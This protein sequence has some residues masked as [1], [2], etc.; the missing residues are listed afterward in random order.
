MRPRAYS[1]PGCFRVGATV[2]LSDDEL[3]AA[4]DAT[5]AAWRAANPGVSDDAMPA[6]LRADAN[7]QHTGLLVA[8]WLNAETARQLALPGGEPA[9]ALHVTL[10]YCGDTTEMDDLTL[11]RAVAAVDR[12]VSYSAPLTGKVAGY[13]RF[14]ASETSDGRDVFY[15]AVDVPALAELRQGIANELTWAGCPPRATHGFTPHITLAYLDPGAPN[16]V[17]AVPSWP[18]R[19]GAVTVRM[20]D[21]GLT[22]PLNGIAGPLGMV[23]ACDHESGAWALFNELQAYADAPEWAPFLPQPGQYSHPLYGQINLTPERIDRFVDQFKAGVYQEKLPVDAEH[24]L[25]MSGAVG[26]I[27]DMRVNADGSADARVDWNDRGK[28]LIEGDRFRYVSPSWRETWQDPVTDEVYRDVAIGLAITTRPFFK[29]RSGLRPLVASEGQLS[30]PD[31]RDGG[32]TVTWRRDAAEARKDTDVTK[33]EQ[34]KNVAPVA[35]TEE[36]ARRFA[37]LETKLAEREQAFS[38]QA[39][40][41]S[42]LEAAKTASEAKVTALEAD[43]AVLKAEA[44]QKRFSDLVRGR[45]G[46]GDGVA[47]VGQPDENVASLERLAAAFGED[48]EQFRAEVT[49]RQKTAQQF[50]EALKPLGTSERADAAGS[51]AWGHLEVKAREIRAA[52][53]AL[54]EAM[55]MAEAIKRNP[56][57]HRRYTDELQAR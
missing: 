22:I 54:T 37:D 19:F 11:F 30:A 56:E 18:L 42:E 28:A 6:A 38:E 16:P 48:S 53:P 17:E 51:D 50:N 9:E 26:W 46:A 52:E 2:D 10:C 40:K 3:K 21:Q 13:G 27:T 7:K 57:L 5:R 29:E 47:W 24:D 1:A 31:P 41:L 36:Q 15:A 32:Q 39:T 44:Q 43:Q 4:M 23:E 20:G 8:L 12:S 49:F 35:L 14:N 34:D 45:G 55:A 25:S 33:D